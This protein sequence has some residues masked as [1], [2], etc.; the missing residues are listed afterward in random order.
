MNVLAPSDALAQRLAA[1]GLMLDYIACIDEDRLEEWPSFFAERCHYRITHVEDFE[2]GYR[3]GAIYASSKGMLADR[4]ASLREA[5]VYEA[6]RYR[7]IVGPS[8]ILEAEDGLIRASAGFMVLRIMH[9]TGDTSIFMTGTYRDTLV[10]EDGRWLYGEKI[11]V[12]DSRNIDTLL[13]IPI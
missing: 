8:R 11:V 6:Q 9:N 2:A 12:A 4:I 7:H 1:D 10:R 13:A 5:N 3:H